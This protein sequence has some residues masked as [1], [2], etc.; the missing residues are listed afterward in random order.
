MYFKEILLQKEHS[1]LC[2]MSL[3]LKA[4][5]ETIRQP[6]LE[7]TKE[8]RFFYALCLKIQNPYRN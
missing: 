4:D 8:E 5:E 2:S 3:I 1:K 7:E 6:D